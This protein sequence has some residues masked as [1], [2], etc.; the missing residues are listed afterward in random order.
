MSDTHLPLV[1]WGATKRTIAYDA[2]SIS[3][4]LADFA[5]TLDGSRLPESVRERAKLL[6]LDA[7]GIAFASSRFEFARRAYAGIV[8]FGSGEF[9]VIGFE[10]M[11]PLR[12]AAIMN[13]VL[14][15]G[16]DYDDT[17]LPGAM[18][19]C[20]SVVPCA[21]A[22]GAATQASG[23]AVLE[24]TIVGLE[25][26]ARISAAGSG[27]FQK[28]GFHPT[29]ICGTMASSLVAGRLLG[30]DREARMRAQGIALSLASGSMQP[31]QD[32][33]W[34]KRLHPG[35]AAASGITA[36]H[37][38]RA[39][40]TGPQAA[41]EGRFGFYTIFLGALAGDADTALI[42]RGLGEAW[43][44]TRSSI[45]LYPACHQSHPFM[46]AAIRLAREHDLDPSTIAG[47][48]TLVS[49]MTRELVCEPAAAK[50]RPDSSYSAQFSL[51]Y[52]MAACLVR[53]R[54]GLAEIEEPVFSDPELLALADIVRYEIDPRAGFPKTRSGEVIV[55]M[56]D[57]R[58]LAARDEIVPDEPAASEAIVAKFMDNAGMSLPRS[59]AAELAE[60][61]LS[62]EREPDVRALCAAL[63]L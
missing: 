28:A 14:V 5:A 24:A 35:W 32:G 6:M 60:R 44:F 11:L 31:M 42:T 52:A 25:A 49:D 26:A 63:R 30:L 39:G 23:S 34:T 17:Y 13:G 58:E 3:Q 61:I 29:G 16:L 59:R 4:T 15:H 9:A 57:G 21:L 40:F 41:Y 38:A 47:V 27:G 50:R 33:T 54:F 10:G 53:R 45:K 55:R 46:N 62:I 1:S 8:P 56:R 37:M 7:I 48:T 51:P 22:M 36:A 2:V 19:T 20:A 18:H 12:E 43:E